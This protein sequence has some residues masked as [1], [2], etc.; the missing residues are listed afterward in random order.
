MLYAMMGMDMRAL[1]PWIEI[2]S[3]EARISGGM[4]WGH[5]RAQHQPLPCTR[6]AAGLKLVLQGKLDGHSC[7]SSGVPPIF[8]THIDI[9]FLP[10][11]RFSEFEGRKCALSEGGGGMGAGLVNKGDSSQQAAAVKA[12]EALGVCTQL[13]EAAAE[14]GWKEP[15][16]IQSQAIP[17]V[18]QGAPP[19]GPPCSQE[20]ACPQP[21]VGETTSRRAAWCQA[22]PPQP[23]HTPLRPCT[24]GR[25]DQDI[26]GLAQTGSGKTGAFALPI[27]QVCVSWD[28]RA[29][30]GMWQLVTWRS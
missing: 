11:Q 26:I 30:S 1:G 2:P 6:H 19:G 10:V 9:Y 29:G 27:L 13:A 14:L 28:C 5:A 15:T 25:A 22:C 3:W 18:L 20:P 4:A 8:W 7:T 12:F 17:H 23:G 24:T 21:R 16:E